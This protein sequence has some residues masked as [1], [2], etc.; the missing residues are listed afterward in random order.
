M[1][2]EIEALKKQLDKA[3]GARE[4]LAAAAAASAAGAGSCPDATMGQ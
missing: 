3:E 4:A 2:N 1:K